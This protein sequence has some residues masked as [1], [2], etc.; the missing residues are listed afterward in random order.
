DGLPDQGR[1]LPDGINQGFDFTLLSKQAHRIA[2]FECC[3]VDY[4]WSNGNGGSLPD[5]LFLFMELD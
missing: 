3:C 1:A 5:A 4:S 2:V